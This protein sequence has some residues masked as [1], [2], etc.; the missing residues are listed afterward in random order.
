MHGLFIFADKTA[1]RG[2]CNCTG[3]REQ[4]QIVGMS[5]SP[6][7][8]MQRG[9]DGSS[10]QVEYMSQSID[11]ATNTGAPSAGDKK[12]SVAFNAIK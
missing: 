6:P 4:S 12:P 8:Y 11:A 10:Q 7:L 5:R 3:H 1:S 2:H 9:E